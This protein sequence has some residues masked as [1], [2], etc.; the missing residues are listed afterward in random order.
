MLK[1]TPKKRV[2]FVRRITPVALAL[3]GVFCFAA[4]PFSSPKTAYA[5]T[6]NTI[7]FQA[8]LQS[9]SGAI[10]P[11]GNYNVEFKLYDA[12]SSSGSS[13]GS[14][15]GDAH[16]L[17]VETRTSGNVVTV[18]DGYLT[19]NLGSVS[20]FS[21]IDWS[22]QLYLTMN[23]GGTGSPSWDGEMSPRLPL[24]AVPYAFQAGQ[25]A[26]TSSGIK[27]TL[28]IQAPTVGNQTFQIQDQGAGGTY[29]ILTQNQSDLRY[30]QLQG[31]T[32]GT[33]QTGNFNIT[34]TGIAA[35]LQASL[36]QTADGSAASTALSLRSGNTTGGSGLSTG[37]VTIKSGDG[38]GT[39]TSS[40]NINI[41][42]GAKTGSGTTG[43]INIGATNATAVTITPATT[44]GGTVGLTSTTGSTGAFYV[45]TTTGN[46]FFNVDTSNNRVTIGIVGNCTGG[47]GSGRLCVNNSS[48]AA[49]I[50]NTQ[51]VLSLNVSGSA[52]TSMGQR[53]A[54]SDTSTSKANT[55]TALYV[56]NTGTTNASAVTNGLFV[57]NPSGLGGGNLIQLQS[58]SSDVFKITNAGAATFKGGVDINDTADTGALTVDNVSGVFFRVDTSNSKVQIGDPAGTICSGGGRFC[59]GQNVTSGTGIVN[60]NN[61]E[62]INTSSG[63][64]ILGQKIV[65]TDTS[66]TV[67]N[68]LTGLKI[69]YTSST[70]TG[71]SGATYNGIVVQVPASTP[72]T[73]GSLLQLQN[74]ATN[75]LNIN[76]AGG[77]L[78][79]TTANTANA[80][81]ITNSS[82]T[83]VFN[84]ATNGNTVTFGNV[85]STGGA[86]V[87][88]SLIL[89]DGTS[90]NRSLTINTAALGASRTVTLDDVTG[91]IMMVQ[92]GTPTSQ[93][94]GFTVSGT[95][96]AA[97]FVATSNVQ[98]PLVQTAD[99]SGASTAIVFRSGNTTGGSALS[100]GTVTIKSGDGS[101][102]N[103]S[104]GNVS[105]DSGSISG[106]GTAGTV[107]V[108]GTNASG[109]TVGNTSGAS[110]LTLQAGT[111]NVSITGATATTYT[112]GASGTTGAITLGQSTDTNTINIGN[113]TTA[114]GKTQTITVGG[115]ATGTGKAVIT[116][117][118]TNG[119]SS[120]ALNAGSGNI[121][122]TTAG[123]TSFV[124]STDSTSAFQIQ[125]HNSSSNLLIADTTNTRI[126]IG[127]TSP[128]Y[129]LDV[130]GDINI[131]SGKLYYANGSP[132][133]SIAACSGGQVLT[134]IGVTAGIITSIGGC[135]TN[136]GGISPTLQNVY[137]NSGSTDPQI[138][139]TNSS[140][141]L[142]L[143]DASGS[144]ITNLFQI[145]DSAGSST[146][147]K[148]TSSATT[149]GNL[150]A[151]TSLQ[152][153]LFQTADGAGASTAV[154]FRSGNTTGGS[155]LSTGGVTIKSGD[156]SGTN[157]SSG[158]VSIDSG[159]ISGTGTAGTVTVGGTNASG[160][161]VGNTS[162]AAALT[163]QAG[164]GNVAITGATG[165]TYTIGATGTTG[166]IT[167]GQ[168]TDTNTIAI[169]SGTTATAKTQTVSIAT[170]ATGTGK[171][172]ITIGNT[173]GASSVTIL[174]GTGATNIGTVG[175]STAGSTTH[176][177]DTSD[178]T[179]AQAVTIGSAA[180]NTGNLTII[181][182]GSTTSTSA[183]AIQLLPATA[184]TITLGA[185]AGT[186]AITLGR[187]TA[188]NTITIGNGNITSGTQTITIGNG[189]TS[190]GIEAVTIGSTNSTS[191]LLLQG[192][193]GS[194]AVSI[195]AGTSGTISLATTNANT[196][197][198]GNSSGSITVAGS[199]R[200]GD[201]SNNTTF[202]STN[203][204]PT[205]SG[206]ARHNAN[207]NLSPEFAGATITAPSGACTNASGTMTSDNDTASPYHNYYQWTT[208]QSGAAQCYD[209]WVRIPI[210][211]DF[212]AFGSRG[213]VG[214]SP[215]INIYTK[216]SDLTNSTLNIINMYDSTNS[217]VSWSSSSN[218][219]T[220][221]S[222]GTWTQKTATASSG[223]YSAGGYIVLDIRLQSKSSSTAQL[224]EINIPYVTK[225]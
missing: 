188:A 121:L 146:Y 116:I 23:I 140:G 20:A 86:G 60:S 167:V 33:A 128:S 34:G 136:G 18:R 175:S 75:I 161:T 48:T 35:T 56:D 176:I 63:G 133:Q 32:P 105:I 107:T 129:T 204:E 168:S 9:S 200:V 45:D 192:G 180:A 206:N 100:T 203:Y 78:L 99:S 73:N 219:I 58:A 25:L 36:F 142:K 71:A 93:T 120:L 117:G 118:N 151:T 16:C 153:P 109:V 31:S 51:N 110:S 113:A 70:N 82:N 124:S 177:A 77:T 47:P 186:G 119:A 181:Q 13:Q 145:Q 11:D 7:N 2:L 40:G 191:S 46:P 195:Q 52:G 154:A 202:D 213:S 157:T 74:G 84:V 207:I 103:T 83:N 152:G 96:T 143:R 85:T 156:G 104:S 212:S 178:A 38:S 50:V 182:G 79:H 214:S 210:P 26:T 80:F 179:N 166:T 216:S 131:G 61:I 57:N 193:T 171:A 65:M 162:G 14:C 187:S 41:D 172:V 158:N 42:S 189:A 135:A 125:N 30:L 138:G 98:T 108:G 217:A 222:T 59:V 69:D 141:G 165:T 225:W 223:T 10:V 12:S 199:L 169:G 49:N 174:S 28:A 173:N 220:P 132:G 5:T 67:A 198:V 3:F 22:Q 19:V 196:L 150:V 144:T 91:T 134:N 4:L 163:L 76:D 137:D 29:N 148:V 97:S 123:N 111:G 39:N 170:A 21:G 215:A 27:S 164:T 194:S 205:L 114:T 44:F 106:T 112:I 130:A 87:A 101:G 208:T 122:A 211:D 90:T 72:G 139:L 6:S 159:S 185:S 68:T 102:T 149:A 92:S 64:I 89:A 160:V 37:A 43:S 127:K 95:G 183:A 15:S 55:N 81:Q 201:A 94:G 218:N 54:I 66:S 147:F 88:A 155:A 221:G 115:S 62:T 53:I 8:R 24:T 197:T 17:W 1:Q 209:I 126:G 190:S 184:G 224:G